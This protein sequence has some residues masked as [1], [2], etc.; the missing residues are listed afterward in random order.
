MNC[1]LISGIIA[2]AP[3]FAA[4]QEIV[5]HV[6]VGTDD[7]IALNTATREYSSIV[8]DPGE[9]A[10]SYFCGDI[11][12]WDVQI[13]EGAEQFVMVKPAKPGSI[14]DIQILTDKGHNYTVKAV[15]VSGKPEPVD[16]KLF[17]EPF[18]KDSLKKPPSLFSAAEV[19]GLKAKLDE[20]N[21]RNAELSK[22]S[23]A[24]L[25]RQADT[26]ESAVP[27][28]LHFDYTFEH[29]KAPF[30]LQSVWNDGKFTYIKASP[31]SETASFYSVKDGK[32]NLVEMSYA[33]GVYTIRQVIQGGVLQVGKKK[34][35]VFL[36]PG[37]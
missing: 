33:E 10:L 11:K 14:T 4:Q 36:K 12:Y 35:E 25:K 1:K 13:I 37:A 24:E 7:I 22:T 9:K 2:V 21:K 15:E 34:T 30:Y 20:S 32:Q 23:A 6:T 26:L 17:V 16:L 8:L 28:S 19:D 31:A 18:D 5:R 3:L 29:N 27:H